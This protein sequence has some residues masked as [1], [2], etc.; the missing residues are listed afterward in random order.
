MRAFYANEVK[1]HAFYANEVKC[2]HFPEN[3]ENAR[4]FNE[5]PYPVG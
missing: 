4:I 2:V 1:M 5:R 3:A